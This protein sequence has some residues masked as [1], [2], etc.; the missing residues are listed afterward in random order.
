MAGMHARRARVPLRRETAARGATRWGRSWRCIEAPC[1]GR[2][3]GWR[4]C[5]GGT[6]PQRWVRVDYTL[7]IAIS[8]GS[9]DGK[10]PFVVCPVVRRRC[11]PGQAADSRAG[12]GMGSSA[13]ERPGMHDADGPELAHA[14]P[15][16]TWGHGG[17]RATVVG[18]ALRMT[19][20]L[21]LGE[22]ADEPV[23]RVSRC[24]LPL[25]GRPAHG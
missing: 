8:P 22:P 21:H 18:V 20:P 24:R 10:H 4:E 23:R 19:S 25:L 3:E 15:S 1:T 13:A 5:A 11:R 9:G 6:R 7:Q 2:V 17:G 14:R 12:R 16:P